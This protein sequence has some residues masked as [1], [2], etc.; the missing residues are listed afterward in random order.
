MKFLKATEA[1]KHPRNAALNMNSS[2]HSSLCK[3][4]TTRFANLLRPST[5]LCVSKTLSETMDTK[6]S[7][8]AKMVTPSEDP[9]RPHSLPSRNSSFRRR[10]LARQLRLAGIKEANLACTLS[11]TDFQTAPSAI[12]LKY[13]KRQPNRLP[14]INYDSEPPTPTPTPPPNRTVFLSLSSGEFSPHH[15]LHTLPCSPPTRKKTIRL[16]PSCLNDTSAWFPRYRPQGVI[17][18]EEEGGGWVCG[19]C[20]RDAGLEREGERRGEEVLYECLSWRK[21]KCGVLA[22]GRCKRRIEETPGGRH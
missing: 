4:L 20:G 2:K 3:R 5:T 9:V 10:H 12:T 17:E 13:P 19:V 16:P 11:S 6:Q 14:G 8:K 18:L 21:G 22:C 1:H 15:S 7:T